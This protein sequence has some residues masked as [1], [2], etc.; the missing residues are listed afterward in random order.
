MNYLTATWPEIKDWH[1][2]AHTHDIVEHLVAF[3]NDWNIDECALGLVIGKRLLCT[4]QLL[5]TAPRELLRLLQQVDVMLLLRDL[6]GLVNVDDIERHQVL[7]PRQRVIDLLLL[8]VLLKL[9]VLK[10][11]I[12]LRLG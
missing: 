7:N 12:Y 5:I 10:L 3:D 1:L 4:N 6:F 8:V 11:F 9:E 2:F